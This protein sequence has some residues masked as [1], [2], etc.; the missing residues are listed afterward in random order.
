[1]KIIQ[2]L[3]IKIFIFINF[4]N[5]NNT[6][7]TNP[8]TQNKFKTQPNKYTIPDSITGHTGSMHVHR[9][10]RDLVHGKWR[11][12]VEHRRHLAGWN[13]HLRRPHL[14]IFRHRWNHVVLRSPHVRIVETVQ[15][16]HVHYV[17]CYRRVIHRR[18]RPRDF[19]RFFS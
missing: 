10:R 2:K 7:S 4:N 3:A 14:H 11:Q 12:I 6:F 19:Q 5:I 16:G 13:P 17:F 8:L 9:S 1:M 18:R 15:L